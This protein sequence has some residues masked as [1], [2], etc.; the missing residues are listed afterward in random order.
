MQSLQLNLEGDQLFCLTEGKGPQKCS[1][2][3][4][5][6][7]YSLDVVAVLMLI[8]TCHTLSGVIVETD[9]DEDKS[10]FIFLLEAGIFV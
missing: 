7:I 2:C 10:Y 9:Q 1:G 3:C 5:Q 8:H 4:H 6:H